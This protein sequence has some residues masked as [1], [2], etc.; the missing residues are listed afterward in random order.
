MP[1]RMDAHRISLRRHPTLGINAYGHVVSEKV[2]ITNLVVAGNLVDHLL[3]GCSESVSMTGNVSYYA[4][5][6]NV[7]A[8]NN[9]SVSTPRARK[10]M[11]SCMT[12]LATG[13][14]AAT[15]S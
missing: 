13:S 12:S 2:Y 9:N 6:S 7:V 15:S 1:R 4:I 10:T 3:T 5:L 11:E 8:Y 14:S